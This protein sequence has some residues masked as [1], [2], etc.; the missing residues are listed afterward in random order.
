MKLNTI[1]IKVFNF[2]T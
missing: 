2:I 1:F